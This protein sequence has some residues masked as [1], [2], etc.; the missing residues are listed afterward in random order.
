[1][2]IVPQSVE[3]E[4]TTPDVM[5][6]IARAGKAWYRSEDKLTEANAYEFVKMLLVDHMSVIE[7]AHAS[8]RVTCDLGV[9]HM[10]LRHR[11]ISFSPENTGL[12]NYGEG[13]DREITLI[14]PP[15]LD[16]MRPS[17]EKSMRLCEETYFAMLD[18]GI[19]PQIAGSVLPNALRT[20]FVATANFQEWRYFLRLR[21]SVKVHPPMREVADMIGVILLRECP[22]VFEDVVGGH[23]I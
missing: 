10:F 21:A 20:K 19:T 8:L 2:K 16:E 1:M 3:L 5:L 9:T 7:H 22:I 14:E 4:F 18:E 6:S 15:G 11:H 12:C 23:G 17:W 13:G